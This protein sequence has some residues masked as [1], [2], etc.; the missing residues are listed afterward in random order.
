M[1]LESGPARTDRN[2]WLL[3]TVVCLGI[4]AWF[5][6]DGKW[7]YYNK[8]REAAELK[9]KA[10]PFGGTL[11]FDELSDKVDKQKFEE[12]L[13]KK[14]TPQELYSQLGEP[15]TVG[16]DRYFLS[17]YGYAQVTVKGGQATLGNWVPW[18]DI[19]DKRKI[20]E[21]FY[22]AAVWAVP[23]LYF[24][25]RLIKAATLHVV[26][27]DEGMVYGGKRVAFAAMVSLRDYSPK[28]WIDLYY[29]VGERE[30][31]LRLD[32]EK[33]LLF[34]DIVA[35][36]CQVKGF[37]NEVKEHAEQKAREQAAEE[38]EANEAE[39]K[40]SADAPEEEGQQGPPSA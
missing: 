5:A 34:D 27:D 20:T 18:S 13:G 1:R 2:W 39:A 10:Q 25:Y 9:L 36:L 28:G 29:K 26:I 24:L 23:G 14:P 33:V 35:A 3:R 30:R 17:R 22:W 8:I 40:E 31:K 12:V 6:Y 21:Q 11:K 7:G 38:A 19:K 15:R 32:N 16:T 4:A 37:R